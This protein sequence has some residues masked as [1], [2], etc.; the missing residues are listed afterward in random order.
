M[1]WS[2]F[3]WGAGPF[4][5]VLVCQA[6]GLATYRS[7][8]VCST[9]SDPDPFL[10]LPGAESAWP[11]GGFPLFAGC[12]LA[13]SLPGAW[14]AFGGS[15]STRSRLEGRDCF[16][17]PASAVLEGRERPWRSR[18]PGALEEG[19]R[20][21]Q[22]KLWSATM[23]T[24]G[25]R[26]A[27][28]GLHPAEERMAASAPQT[29]TCNSRLLDRCLGFED[30]AKRQ[31]WW[32]DATTEHACWEKVELSAPQTDETSRLPPHRE[33]ELGAFPDVPLLSCC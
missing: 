31:R 17:T 18:L 30:P 2:I 29:C 13:F 4:G 5:D 27:F 33:N 12:F 1:P 22:Q 32:W 8:L 19:E 15:S 21:G 7:Q 6:C 9:Y 3:W 20:K 16:Y 24:A 23:L 10:T 28:K 14:K 25:T 26:A 11:R